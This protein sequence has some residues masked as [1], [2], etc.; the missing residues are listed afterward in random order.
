[1]IQK[2]FG[3]IWLAVLVLGLVSPACSAAQTAS[4][5]RVPTD[6][7]LPPTVTQVPTPTPVPTSTPKPSP[8]P[9]I[10][11]TQGYEDFYAVV[12]GYN[13][14]GYFTSMEGSQTLLED[15][16]E[17]WPQ[18][19]WYQWWPTSLVVTNFVYSGH[20]QWS[21]A[22][23]T[24]EY[25]GCG[26]AFA[27]QKD[28][29]NYT[30]FLDKSRVV[31]YHYVA[32]LKIPQEIGK[33]KGSGRVSVS[34]PYEADFSMVLNSNHA[35]VYVDKAFVGEYTLSV[36]SDMRGKFGF[37]LLSGTNKDYG[38]KCDITNSR[39]WILNN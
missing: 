1:M 15:F 4:Q 36:D 37:T 39:L 13:D 5:T 2:P 38:T 12:K 26:I 10:A 16:S 20:F 9:D 11:A 30:F 18:I 3:R 6:T 34:S 19:D 23:Q 29:S 8:T 33:T 31:A 17:S 28:G 7:P 21:V 32:N 14:K 27:I 25:S 24:P 35:Y 22:S